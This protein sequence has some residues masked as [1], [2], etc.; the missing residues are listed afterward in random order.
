MARPRHRVPERPPLHVVPGYTVLVVDTNILLSSLSIVASL[1]ESRRWTVVVPL[2]VI[3]E[4]DGLSINPPPL[5]KAAADALSYLTTH[6]P[7]HSTSL[8]VQTSK[9]NYLMT[10]SV[11]H[12]Q[13]DFRGDTGNMDR[14]MDDLILRSAVWQAEHFMDRSALLKGRSDDGGMTMPPLTPTAATAKVVLLSFDRNL[15]LK[16]R[17]R[18]LDAADERDMASILAA[19]S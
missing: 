12:E 13:I 8:K 11:R 19:G 6:V 7:A 18:D 14:N 2:A 16:A 1:V 3:H 4:L 5:G 9:G 15:R 10:L 17:A